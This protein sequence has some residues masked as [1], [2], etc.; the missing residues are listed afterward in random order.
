MTKDGH[1]LL[2]NIM[3]AWGHK[4]ALSTDEVLSAVGES[5]FKRVRGENRARFLVYQDDL[6]GADIYLRIPEASFQ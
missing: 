3:K 4:N 2:K 5:L 1:F 6:S